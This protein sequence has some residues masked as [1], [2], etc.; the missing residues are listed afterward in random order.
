MHELVNRLIRGLNDVHEPFMRFDHEIFTA[1]AVDKG[2]PRNI[3]VR[4]IRGK[5]H[6]SHDFGARANRGVQYLLTAVVDDPAV[7]RF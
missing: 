5:R 6:G 2:T 1:V 3:V 7:I 4:T